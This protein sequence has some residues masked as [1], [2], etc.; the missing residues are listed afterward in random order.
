MFLKS[1]T[2]LADGDLEAGRTASAHKG[3]LLESEEILNGRAGI[4]FLEEGY[5][6][7]W[8]AS[9]EEWH[10]HRLPPQPTSGHFFPDS[11]GSHT[12]PEISVLI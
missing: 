1:G 6:R 11:A 8:R 5:L 7:C 2:V 4:A 9:Q 3:S 10:A 12:L